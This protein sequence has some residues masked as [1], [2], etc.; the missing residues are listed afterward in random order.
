MYIHWVSIYFTLIIL[1]IQLLIS[2]VNGTG[3]SNQIDSKCE[4]KP[5]IVGGGKCIDGSTPYYYMRKGSDSGLK[6][7]QIHFQGIVCLY[8]GMS[9][10]FKFY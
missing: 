10:I 7:W 6:K 5:L 8:D 9:M 1:S 3:R 2:I 4:R